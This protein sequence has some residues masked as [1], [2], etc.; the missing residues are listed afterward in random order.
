MLVIA[1][2]NLLSEVGKKA[3]NPIWGVIFFYCSVGTEVISNAFLLLAMFI[4]V[5]AMVIY[6]NL[7]SPCM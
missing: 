5:Y 1:M 2:H 7:F 4:A 6:Y 3:T